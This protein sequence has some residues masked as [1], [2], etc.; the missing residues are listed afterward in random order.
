MRRVPEC[1][2]QRGEEEARVRD[3]CA[4][5]ILVWPDIGAADDRT[6]ESTAT[7]VRAGGRFIQSACAVRS[8]TAGD[9]ADH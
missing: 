4:G 3:V 9:G 1:L 7:T 5:P 8:V 2:R 6:V